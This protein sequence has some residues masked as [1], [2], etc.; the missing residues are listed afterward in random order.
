MYL[1]SVR[2]KTDEPTPPFPRQKNRS[3]I[4]V[5]KSQAFYPRQRSKN[6]RNNTLIQQSDFA[7]VSKVFERI[8]R[9]ISNL[10]SFHPDL[11]VSRDNRLLTHSQV[12]EA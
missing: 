8:Y 2:L 3:I 5:S 12:S 7:I 11:P 10:S 1:A 9:L 4:A 6:T